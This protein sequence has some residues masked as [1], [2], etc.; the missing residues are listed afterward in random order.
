MFNRSLKKNKKELIMHIYWRIQQDL[1]CLGETLLFH[2]PSLIRA[3]REWVKKNHTGLVM[4]GCMGGDA[5]MLSRK[6]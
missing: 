4:A 5:A 2:D 6:N 3:L 1:A